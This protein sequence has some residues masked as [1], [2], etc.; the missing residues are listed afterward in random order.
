M[1]T[2]TL[3]STLL[4][5]SLSMS[6]MSAATELKDSTNAVGSEPTVLKS[7]SNSQPSQQRILAISHQNSEGFPF[8][9][10]SENNADQIVIKNSIIG[11]LDPWF[12]QNNNFLKK[13]SFDEST[14]G[15][16]PFAGHSFLSGCDAIEVVSFKGTRGVDLATFL[17]Q[18]ASTTLLQRILDRNCKLFID[19]EDTGATMANFA[20][21]GL[22]KQDAIRFAIRTSKIIDIIAKEKAGATPEIKPRGWLSTL[23]FGY[24]GK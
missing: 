5:S 4:V 6:L 2:K 15:L 9:Q 1:S 3:L 20:S 8:T 10:T 23:T 17:E 16:D 19:M 14:I 13:V 24:L 11:F 22:V 7:T 18:Y 21:D 12:F